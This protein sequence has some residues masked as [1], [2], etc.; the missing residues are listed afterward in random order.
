MTN[1]TPHNAPHAGS[2]TEA[3]PARNP[4][5]GSGSPEPPQGSNAIHD[6]LNTL[7]DDPQPTRR[8]TLP[9]MI[10]T[11]KRSPASGDA[12]AAPTLPTAGAA[13][14]EPLEGSDAEAY[15]ALK[16]KR[17]ERRRKKLIHRAIVA[18]ISGVL[19]VG[20][21]VVV[22]ALNQQPE[23]TMEAVT[24]FATQGTFSTIIDAKGTLKPLSSTVITPEVTGQIE[25]INVVAGQTV[26]EGDT[27]MTI[28]NPELDRA[29][30]EA[31]RALKQ[32]RS[33][34]GL[35]Q[36]A[37]NDAKA[38]ASQPSEDQLGGASDVTGAQQAVNAAQ[39]QVETAQAAYND[40]VAKAALRTVKAPAAGSVVALNAQVG[41]DV[42]ESLGGAGAT[43]PLMQIADLSKMKV[44]IQVEERDIAHVAVDQTA[45]I[46]CPAFP[47]LTLT[48]RVTSIASIAS[49]D[50]ANM[51]YDGMGSPTFAVDILIDAPDARLKPGMT[52]EVSLT[53]QQID[54][55]IMVPITALLT[56]DGENYY[57]NVETDPETHAAER[58]DVQVVAK[59][60]DFAV[61]GKPADAPADQNPDMPESP[62]ADG[63]T[64]VIAGGM[65]PEVDGMD[66]AAGEMAVG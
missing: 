10:P 12:P 54:N 27:L 20:G 62:L 4:I 41:A 23:Q 61:V 28:K 29:V 55:V 48:G 15:A 43:G 6:F 26:A 34:L 32:A 21:A 25:S 57:V 63:D 9:E 16:A 66:G 60:D 46:T 53:T 38:H 51:S 49:T 39:A 18:G 65:M 44:T 56:D 31:D 50:T 58:L 5:A 17:A 35:A 3:D 33:D 13:P 42:A 59:N 2:G 52:A 45:T 37:L 7:D 19:V 24:D 30:T 64:L 8:L 47:D 14:E 22:S 11:I 36:Q 40:A 1:S